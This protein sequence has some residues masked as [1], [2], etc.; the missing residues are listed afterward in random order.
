[1]EAE[2]K[3]MQAAGPPRSYLSVENP[4]ITLIDELSKKKNLTH[5]YIR[6]GDLSVRLEKNP[7][8]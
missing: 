5:V 6:K 1:G 4:L 8:P 7:N 3:A 2:V